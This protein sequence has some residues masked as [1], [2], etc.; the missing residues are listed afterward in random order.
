MGRIK[1][2]DDF[3]EHFKGRIYFSSRDAEIF[4]KSSGAK[5]DYIKLMLHNLEKRNDIFRLKRGYYT[6]NV[7]LDYIG[8]IFSPF[9]YG[10]QDALSLHG[11]WEQETNPVIITTRKVRTGIREIGGRNVIIHRINR[12]FFFGYQSLKVGNSYV[13]VSDPEKTLLDF[14]YFRLNIPDEALKRIV[15]EIDMKRMH[16]YLKKT[17]KAVVNKVNSWLLSK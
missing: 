9:Y 10:L 8:F 14:A 5:K 3:K 6:F 15:Q 16:F 4:L 2:M 11:F 7:N 1:Y 12:R 13:P 17:N